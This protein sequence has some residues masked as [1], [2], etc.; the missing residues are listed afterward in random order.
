MQ[1]YNNETMQSVK[2]MGDVLMN[3]IKKRDQFIEQLLEKQ[4]K[5]E[6]YHEEESRIS[7]MSNH[8]N[9]ALEEAKLF[10][11]KRELDEKDLLVQELECKN[12]EYEK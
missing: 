8:S 2:A 4:R 3:Q 9:R 7:L 11:L 10:E 12:K 5:Y 1:K 6:A